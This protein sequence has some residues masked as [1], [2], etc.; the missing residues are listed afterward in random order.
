MIFLEKLANFKVDK[1][2]NIKYRGNSVSS[3]I[4]ILIIDDNYDFKSNEFCDLW[5]WRRSKLFYCINRG[6]DG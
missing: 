4:P 6:K 3:T 1:P 5:I 2:S